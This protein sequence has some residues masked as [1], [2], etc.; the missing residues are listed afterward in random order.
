M[1]LICSI[2]CRKFERCELAHELLRYSIP[3][4]ELPTWLC[5]VEH[6]SSYD[7]RARNPY[8]YDGSSDH[9]LFQVNDRYWCSP[10]GAN[11]C[12]MP[13]SNHYIGDDITCVKTIYRV[14]GYSAW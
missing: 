3:R 6:E 14:H 1:F 5:I 2:D 12:K 7:T 9:G 8:N 13:C 11:V 10:G 4:H